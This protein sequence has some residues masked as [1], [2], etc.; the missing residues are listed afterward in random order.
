[1]ARNITVEMRDYMPKYYGDSVIV[2]NIIDRESAEFTTLNN[3]IQD[4]LN[5]FFVDTATWGLDRWEKICDIETDTSKTYDNRRAVIKSKLRGIGTVTVAM[6]KNVAES[7][8]TNAVEVAE[9]NA[10]YLIDITFMGARGVPDNLTDIQNILREMIPAHLGID[11]IFTYLPFNELDTQQ[12]NTID[13]YTWS[14]LEKA[15]F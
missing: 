12:W 2:G 7:Y 13:T 6:I 4:V 3:D 5:Q 14:N 10:N 8:Y 15:F 1:M 9:D 11:Y